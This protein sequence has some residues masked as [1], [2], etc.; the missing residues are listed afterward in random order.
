MG[1][2][3]LWRLLDASGKPVVLESL[4]GKVLAID[5]SIWI[6]Q[7]LQG[8]QNQHGTTKPNAHLLGLFIRICKLLYYRIKPVFVFD[9]GVPMLKKNT[10]ASRRKQK[11]IAT[12]KAQKMKAD[13]ISNLIKHTMAKT[14]L[15]QDPK[16]DPD[17]GAM[18]MT[19]NLLT[20]RPEE[21]MF[22]LPDMSSNGDTQTHVIDDDEYDSDVS[23][24]LS[25]RK[26]SKWMGNIHN[27]D[28]AT[29]EFKAL[30]ADV[31][32]DILTDLRETRKQNSWGRLHEMPEESQ[33]FSGFQMRRLLKRR[34][35]QQ[36]LETA[37]KEMGGKTLTLEEL[38]KLLT[39][40]GI[41]T[42]G[43]DAAFRIAA[44]DTTRLIYIS[45]K[46]ALN[47]AESSV[48]NE[49]ETGENESS[50]DKSGEVEPVAGPS[51]PTP[52]V[53]NMNEYELN[54]DSDN[55]VVSIHDDPVPIAEDVNEYAFDSDWESAANESRPVDK[56]YFGKNTRN[57]A[58]TYMLE[59]SGLSQD[60]IIHL[61]SHNNNE[62]CKTAG[63][64]ASEKDIRSESAESGDPM[65]DKLTSLEAIENREDVSKAVKL[66]NMQD[67][68]GCLAREDPLTVESIPSSSE[69]DNSIEVEPLENNAETSEFT[70]K[71][72][73]ANSS[74]EII[75]EERS[76]A[77]L[78][79]VT[80]ADTSDSGSDDFIEIHDVPIPDVSRT[81]TRN[82]NLEITI[83][84]GDKLEDDLFAD[85]FGKMAR[86]QAVS[87]SYAKHV[88]SVDV[89]DEHRAVSV[90][91]DGNNVKKL[92]TISEEPTEEAEKTDIASSENVQS[93]ENASND[94]GKVND[95]LSPDKP[96]EQNN[97]NSEVDFSKESEQKKPVML[98][99]SEEG[100]IKLKDQLEDEQEELTKSI[101]K[102]ERQATNISEQVQ[103]EAQELLRL[104][105]IP[106]VVAPMEAEAQCA[107]LEQS[108][109]TN[110]TITD[111]SDIWLF[112]GQC[113]YKNF[114][115]NS[116]R[117][118]QFCA[119]DIQHHFKL[120]RNQLIQLA[121]L[122][123]SDY[124]TGVAG[125][126][127][128]T[129]LEILAAFPT[130]GDNVLHGLH[131]FYSWMKNGRIAT[132]G[133]AGLRNKLRNVKL[134]R[135]FPNQAVV[136]AYLFP[137]VDESKETFTWGKP[138][139]MLLCDYVR[140]KFGWTKGKFDDTIIPVLRR[141]EEKKSQKILDL[142][143]KTMVSP[144]L[145]ES[146]LSKR[147]Q[148]AVHRLN[149]KDDGEGEDANGET[150]VKKRKKSNAGQRSE[151]EE[152]TIESDVPTC[153]KPKAL[154]GSND[155]LDDAIAVSVVHDRTA[156]EYIPQRERDKANAFEKKLRAIEI[157]RKSKQGLA[158]TK[159]VRRI[160]RKVK[161]EVELSESDSN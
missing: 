67:T 72:R 146:N 60:Q 17:N 43:R 80:Q 39:E 140:R 23:V 44:D 65:G 24:E 64:K 45:D 137:T 81:S 118:Q 139:V 152:K 119:C 121:L 112:G 132:S 15:N 57:P 32:Y 85:V 68:Q 144:K 36:S 143:F 79:D 1:V 27:V 159:K 128:V 14:V 97:T 22:A 6:Y 133:K 71:S 135:D 31:R 74:N 38:D 130:E 103:I 113:V 69:C 157:F 16:A 158:R 52:I 40:Q 55:D 75:P 151:K 156:D 115:N 8:Y 91:E 104:F 84:S 66:R 107:Y 42:K 4:E 26:Q 13:L 77:K 89:N 56:K 161:K 51:N 98:P 33:E 127:P 150:R 50:R 102:L 153:T 108:K 28:V 19:I 155:V 9:G 47:S 117:V 59:Y 129:A 21:D 25:P 70:A 131:N 141:M 154:V 94:D 10:I 87:T 61:I 105:G 88:K 138:N 48:G 46:N 3:G 76:V 120:T 37:E 101:G 134:D 125:I 147:V 20:K 90:P 126:G 100:W 29:N 63:K 18:Q 110:G 145:I 54:D 41:D 136:Q 53:E 123:G 124:T 148:K 114:F 58:L 78:D 35:V 116:K 95:S 106:Y 160:V 92:D 49:A 149:N 5:I 122:V 111:D 82:E 96:T 83:K 7:M 30:P 93:T 34:Y 73:A 62:S 2:Y 11:S 142:Y 99:I 86:S 12:N 109:L